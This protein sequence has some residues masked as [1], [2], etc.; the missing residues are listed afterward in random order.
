MEVEVKSGPLKKVVSCTSKATSNKVIQPI[1]NN[2]LLSSSDGSLMVYATDLDLSIEC[3]LPADVLKPG[4]ITIPAKKLEEIVNKISGEDINFS[5]EKNNI[6][7]IKS[8]KSKFQI[9]GVSSDEFPELIKESKNEKKYFINQAEFIKAV[10]LT[11]FSTSKFDITSILSGVNFVIYDDKFEL[12]ATDGSRLARYI[13]NQS[14]KGKKKEKQDKKS[15]VI[16]FRA[17]A[18]LERLMSSFCEGN[19][20]IQFSFSQG[21]IIFQN[22]DFTISTRL[23]EGNFPEYEN[24]I[25]KEQPNKAIFNRIEL[26]NSLERVAIL[27]NERTSVVKLSFKKNGKNVLL[28]ANSPD[29]GNAKDEIEVN[30]KGDEL[31]I[32]FNYRYLSEA[33]RNLNSQEVVLELGSS[34]S[35]IL[36]KLDKEEDFDY[37]YLIM[38][39]QM[40]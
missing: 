13:G 15:V 34:L 23:I 28:S 18:E 40:R 36:L 26:L 6:T 30:Y 24:L 25:P 7:K 1:L 10:S 8:D 20:D 21:Q 4:K 19:E 33:L 32:A 14:N 9:N 29:Y 11:S 38:P 27:S 22:N 37:N 16:P 31:E 12:G 5:I 35:P 39:V 2:I 17:M 3:K